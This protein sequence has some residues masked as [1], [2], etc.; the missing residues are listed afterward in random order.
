MPS[1][2]SGQVKVV[3]WCLNRGIEVIAIPN[4]GKR[5]FATAAYFKA[6]GL[7]KFFPDLIVFTPTKLAPRGMVIE[8]KCKKNKPS[9]GQLACLKR[10]DALGI[11]AV[12]AS[13]AEE[14]IAHL[15]EFGYGELNLP[16]LAA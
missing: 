4:A 11:V 7:R 13:S 1:E 9:K 8:M 3:K 14:A 2:H 15:V 6:E 12:W 10:L 16:P 5:S